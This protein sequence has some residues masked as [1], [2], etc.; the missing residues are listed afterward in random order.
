MTISTEEI[1]LLNNMNSTAFKCQLGTLI[2]NAENVTAGEIA[3][4]QGSILV[5]NASAV[6]SALD[7]KGDTKLLVGNGTT[8]TSV[9][10]SGE[11]ALANT[12]AFTLGTI[13]SAKLKD[14]TTPA[15]YLEVKSVG[16][17][18]TV[19]AAN[20]TLSIDVYNEEFNS[21]NALSLVYLPIKILANEVLPIP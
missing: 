11:G 5:G 2:Y 16:D 12:G 15:Y 13:A 10:M 20:R 17:G 21:K 1:Y 18:G 19:M 8:I 14:V 9:A 3:L 4:A 6:G 7:A